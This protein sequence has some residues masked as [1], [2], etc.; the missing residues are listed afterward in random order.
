VPS[1]LEFG[2]EGFIRYRHFRFHP[3]LKHARRFYPHA[4]NV[5]GFFVCKLKKMGNETGAPG[6]GADADASNDSEDDEVP[7]P[8]AQLPERTGGQT[9][10][11]K[12]TAI[13]QS[14]AVQQTKQLKV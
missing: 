1:S 2:R 10:S 14:N 9:S 5:D 3:S 6:K 7:Q 4:H 12:D 8:F 11:D 13:Q